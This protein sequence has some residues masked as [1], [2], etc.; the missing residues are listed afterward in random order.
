MS[1]FFLTASSTEC[2]CIESYNQNG[3]DKK[4]DKLCA[5]KRTQICGGSINEF[6]IYKLKSKI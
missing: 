2:Y 1:Y 6:S 3:H 5:G 4:C